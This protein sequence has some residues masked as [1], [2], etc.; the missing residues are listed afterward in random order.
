LTTVQDAVDEEKGAGRFL[1][2]L[3]ISDELAEERGL[4]G[5]LGKQIGR[6]ADQA[7]PDHPADALIVARRQIS[8][9][10]DQ[11]NER[12]DADGEADEKHAPRPDFGRGAEDRREAGERHAQE[13]DR[14][15]RQGALDCPPSS[16]RAVDGRPERKQ[17][18]PGIGR[19]LH[20]DKNDVLRQKHARPE[21]EP[22]PELKRLAGIELDHIDEETPG[23]EA[24]A[25]P[26]QPCRAEHNQDSCNRVEH[27]DEV[28]QAIGGPRLGDELDVASR[29]LWRRRDDKRRLASRHD[30]GDAAPLRQ[31]TGAPGAVNGRA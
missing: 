6:K 11:D 10:P 2:R 12:A 15:S 3:T 7:A 1:R 18:K 24:R 22:G 23:H 13:H 8:P 20:H 28:E 26:H 31:Q 4:L 29:T 9:A 14:E 30:I 21:L 19:S 17:Q 25:R 16:L 5:E 27:N